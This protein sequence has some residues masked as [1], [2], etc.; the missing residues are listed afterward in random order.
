MLRYRRMLSL[1]KFAAVYSSVY[2]HFNL[3]RH[4]SDGNWFKMNRLFAA[5][6]YRDQTNRE[7]LA[8]V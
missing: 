4:L 8:V 3:E 7:R 5:K 6:I 1:P 2:S